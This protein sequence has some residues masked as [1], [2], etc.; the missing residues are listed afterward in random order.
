MPQRYEVSK[1]HSCEFCGTEEQMLGSCAEVAD[2]RSLA[3]QDARRTLEWRRVVEAEPWPLRA[4]P[5]DGQFE[6]VIHRRE[7]G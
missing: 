4:D 7:D 6:Y 3:E 2:A 5:E 1:V